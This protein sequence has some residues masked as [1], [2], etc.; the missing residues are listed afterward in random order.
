MR[1]YRGGAAPSDDGAYDETGV[2]DQRPEA[3]YVPVLG[4]IAAGVPILAEETVEDVFPLPRQIVGE[5]AAVPA[6]GRR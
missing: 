1:G 4:R 6:Q 3:A 5:G 2:D